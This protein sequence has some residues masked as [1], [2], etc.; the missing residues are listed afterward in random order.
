M[1]SGN[2]DGTTDSTQAG[3]PDIRMARLQDAHRLQSLFVQFV[4]LRA[5]MSTDGK[6]VEF[7]N[8]TPTTGDLM[9]RWGTCA[10]ATIRERTV[11]YLLTDQ[12]DPL[13]MEI[14][15]FYV[16]PEFRNRGLGTAMLRL[17]ED[18]LRRQGMVTMLA[19][20]REVWKPSGRRSETF[21]ES[22]G[23]TPMWVDDP[24]TEKEPL[25][26]L[27]KTLTESESESE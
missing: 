14:V 9:P 10:L 1:H 11:G 24:A 3:A 18:E 7:P 19:L 2:L 17:V 15:A 13:A 27:K 22:H 23:Y 16:E 4:E 26:L 6:P 12:R 21:F 8:V 5:S 25:V 20:S